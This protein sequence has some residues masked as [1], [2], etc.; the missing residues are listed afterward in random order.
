[1]NEIDSTS[2]GKIGLKSKR[3]DLSG[4]FLPTSRATVVLDGDPSYITKFQIFR[5]RYFC[6]VLAVN[7]GRHRIRPLTTVCVSRS[8]NE[9][10]AVESVRIPKQAEL[11]RGMALSIDHS[12]FLGPSDGARHDHLVGDRRWYGANTQAVQTRERAA[13]PLRFLATRE[14]VALC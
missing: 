4:A 12:R 14:T 13:R 10:S 1:M 6:R 9:V 11:C 5:R 2:D 3:V 8:T 7:L